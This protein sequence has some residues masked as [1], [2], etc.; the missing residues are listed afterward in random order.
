L[1]LIETDA[2]KAFRHARLPEHGKIPIKLSL[3]RTLDLIV[4]RSIGPFLIVEGSIGWT[5]GV[6]R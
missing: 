1:D 6:L 3:K 5:L 4:G 2:Q